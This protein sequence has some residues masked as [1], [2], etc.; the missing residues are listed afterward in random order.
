MAITRLQPHRMN[1]LG[2]IENL[3]IFLSSL[4]KGFVHGN[5]KHI[6]QL[7]HNE[8]IKAH[9]RFWLENVQPTCYRVVEIE[10]ELFLCIR[11][12]NS[13]INKCVVHKTSDFVDFHSGRY[14]EDEIAANEYIDK[15]LEKAKKPKLTL[16]DGTPYNKGTRVKHY[17]RFERDSIKTRLDYIGEVVSIEYS[18]HGADY[19]GVLIDGDIRH[20]FSSELIPADKYVKQ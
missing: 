15:E 3:D 7:P 2:F 9:Y 18:V 14:F 11:D 19:V 17:D 20:F 6:A 10:P 1:F 5:E 13:T 8:S 4:P 16:R 12:T